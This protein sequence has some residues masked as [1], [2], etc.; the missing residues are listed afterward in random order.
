VVL[1]SHPLGSVPLV[2]HIFT[3]MVVPHTCVFTVYHV[4]FRMVNPWG[5]EM[6]LAGIVCT[7]PT[8]VSIYNDEPE[9]IR[10]A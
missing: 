8:K 2:G 1:R 5:C 7:P 9:L 10:M 3:K 6:V 4:S